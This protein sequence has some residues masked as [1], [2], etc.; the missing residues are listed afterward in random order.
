MEAFNIQNFTNVFKAQIRGISSIII[1]KWIIVIWIFQIMWLISL[2]LAFKITLF[3][4]NHPI[5][6]VD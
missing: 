2:N 5:L 3:W 6:D 4:R 1:L